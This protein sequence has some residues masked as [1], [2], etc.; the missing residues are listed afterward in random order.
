MNIFESVIIL[1]STFE[2]NPKTPGVGGGTKTRHLVSLAT[3]IFECCK[4]LTFKFHLF[5]NFVSCDG[6]FV[7]DSCCKKNIFSGLSFQVYCISL[8]RRNSPG[9]KPLQPP[10]DSLILTSETFIFSFWNFLTFSRVSNFS[11][12]DQLSYEIMCVRFK[13]KFPQKTCHKPP[14]PWV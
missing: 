5:S 13:Q 8:A 11:W 3:A 9:P 4:F 2:F 10:P 6:K 7:F 1:P 12:K 14:T